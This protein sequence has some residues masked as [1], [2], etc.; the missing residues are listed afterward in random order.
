MFVMVISFVFNPIQ[1]GVSRYMEHQ[2]DVYGMDISGV[3]GET[4]AIAFDKLSAYNLSDPDPNPFIECW[5]YD[6][7]T[8]KKRMTF[9]R[10]YRQSIRDNEFRKAGLPNPPACLTTM[11][12]MNYPGGNQYGLY[13]DT[14]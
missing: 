12:R 14:H 7:P 10:E 5:F 8:L 4:A 2:A 13:H 6:H 1:N 3:S 11:M 9:V